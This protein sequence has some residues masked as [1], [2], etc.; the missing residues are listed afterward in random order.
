MRP[1]VW[2]FPLTCGELI[3]FLAAYVAGGLSPEQRATFD[4]HLAEC[5]ECVGYLRTYQDTVILAKGTFARDDT[6]P[7]DVPEKLV[8]AI[9]AARGSR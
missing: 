8:R 2:S 5:P 1:A 6:L 9:L 7:A 3:D 4:A